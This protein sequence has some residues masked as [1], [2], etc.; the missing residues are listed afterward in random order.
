MASKKAYP[1]GFRLKDIETYIDQFARL[2]RAPGAVWTR[3][4]RRLAPHKPFLL[5]AV[6]D[7][8]ARGVLNSPFIDIH[9]DLNELNDLFAA[10]WRR[11]VPVSQKSSIALPFSRLHNEPFWK[12]VPVSGKEISSAV[13]NNITSVTQLRETALGA[14]F[15]EDLFYYLGQPE[16]RSRLRGVLL[17]KH[18]SDETQISLSEQIAVNMQVF[19]YSKELEELSHLPWIGNQGTRGNG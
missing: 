17:Q 1:E 12:L 14:I 6:A 7:L 11:V 4:T 13:I 5:L 9:G 15:D 8:V 2:R 16:T 10:Y 18:F 19:T 3:A